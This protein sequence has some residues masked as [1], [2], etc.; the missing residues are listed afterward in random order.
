[1]LFRHLFDFATGRKSEPHFPVSIIRSDR[2]AFDRVMGRAAEPILLLEARKREGE[3]RGRI[4]VFQAIVRDGGDVGGEL[5]RVQG[6][7]CATPLSKQFQTQSNCAF[8][9]HQ[10]RS[11]VTSWLW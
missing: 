6:T 10:N 4:F 2:L 3:A 8:P 11:K 5:I 9:E 1:M 7:F